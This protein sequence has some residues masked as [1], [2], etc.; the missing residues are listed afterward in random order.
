MQ[1]KD[2][3][4][5]PFDEFEEKYPSAAVY[6]RRK[7][8]EFKYLHKKEIFVW[9]GD[10]KS[11]NF[12]IWGAPGTG[13]SRWARSQVPPEKIYLKNVNKWWDG[14]E[15]EDWKVILVEDWPKDAKVLVEKVKVW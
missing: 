6:N 8:I 9:N 4:T 13:K 12:W 2:L 14:Y 11:Q 1:I 10:L 15:M 3:M 7:W 5:L